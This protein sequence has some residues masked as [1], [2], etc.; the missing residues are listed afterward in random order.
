MEKTEKKAPRKLYKPSPVQAELKRE[1]LVTYA[2]ESAGG[3][4]WNPNPMTTPPVTDG[5]I[6]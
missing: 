2:D 5:E 6:L 4:G 1:M 3:G